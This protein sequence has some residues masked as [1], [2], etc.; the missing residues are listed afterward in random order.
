MAARLARAGRGRRGGARTRH[1]PGSWRVPLGPTTRTASLSPDV[2]DPGARNGHLGGAAWSR[3][4]RPHAAWSQ[5]GADILL[6]ETIFDTLNA[7]AAIFAVEE[8]FEELGY[9]LPVIISG[10]ITDASGPDALGP[11][12]RARSGTACATRGR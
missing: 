10:T 7:K 8:L 1:G 4:A 3:T 9:R 12:G 2:N 6:I 5:G 11:D